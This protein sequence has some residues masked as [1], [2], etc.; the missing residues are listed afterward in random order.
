LKR[1]DT[2]NHVESEE[3][4]KKGSNRAKATNLHAVETAFK[5]HILK[6]KEET[7]WKEEEARWRSCS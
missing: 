7:E 5:D 6:M 4:W 1:Q 3:E 2:E